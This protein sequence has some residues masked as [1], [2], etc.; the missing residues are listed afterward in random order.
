[1]FILK[2]SS[3][4]SLPYSSYNVVCSLL[5]FYQVCSLNCFFK[6]H[7]PHSS[8]YLKQDTTLS[9]KMAYLTQCKKS[10]YQSCLWFSSG[11][12]HILL[13][14]CKR[15]EAAIYHSSASC[16]RHLP[17]SFTS[18]CSHWL[19]S[20][21]KLTE[22]QACGSVQQYLDANSFTLA[23]ETMQPVFFLNATLP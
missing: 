9:H 6:P 14:Y 13:K 1:M 3:P 15:Q 16:S 4:V 21:T 17:L 22:Q 11:S 2:M 18:L 12:L 10:F 19:A 23:N 8:R 7:K 20:A 5:C